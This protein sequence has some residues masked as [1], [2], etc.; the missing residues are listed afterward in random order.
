MD[1]FKEVM[2]YTLFAMYGSG[3]TLKP[4]LEDDET[5][6]V[7]KV[8]GMREPT[9]ANKLSR[10]LPRRLYTKTTCSSKAQ[11][12]VENV[13]VHLGL[14]GFITIRY[15]P[16]RCDAKKVKDQFLDRPRCNQ[17]RRYERL[18]RTNHDMGC[19][20]ARSLQD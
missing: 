14:E 5:I 12:H 8:N 9:L 11:A 1:W 2:N 6:T 17:R 16:F 7:Q 18:G 4:A 20:I 13:D 19:S 15:N 3:A 10:E